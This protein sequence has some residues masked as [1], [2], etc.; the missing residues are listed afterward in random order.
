[1]RR[2]LN[3]ETSRRDYRQ[4]VILTTV[5]PHLPHRNIAYER[6]TDSGP[7]AL[8]PSSNNRY[9]VVWTARSDQVDELL[10]CSDSEFLERLQR[11]FGDRAGEFRR[12]GKRKT[13]PLSFVNVKQPVRP[14][15]VVAGNAAHTIHPVA[16]QGST[17]ACVMSPHWLRW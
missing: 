1:M 8:L 3:F 11:R 14:R 5:T 4:C 16:G 12:L 2:S 10:Q 13:Y 9:T 6:F 15:I 7:L 17:W